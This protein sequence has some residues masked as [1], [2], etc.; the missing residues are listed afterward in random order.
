M[1]DPLTLFGLFGG[2]LGLAG[3]VAGPKPAKAPAVVELPDTAAQAEAARDSGAIVRV[4]AGKDDK[5]TDTKAV[6]QAVT[7][8]TRVFGRP[9][10]GLGKSGLS[11]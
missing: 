3:S 5:T 4:G 9:V 11:I 2:A 6:E 1:C 8:E 10:G 7:Q